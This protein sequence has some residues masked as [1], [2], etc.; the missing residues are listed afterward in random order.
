MNLFDALSI[1]DSI[2]YNAAIG[3]CPVC[4]SGVDRFRP[5]GTP[6]REKARCPNCGSLE[7]HRLVWCFFKLWTNLFDGQAKSVLHIAPERAMSERIGSIPGVDYLTADLESPLAM[8]KM[9]LTDIQYPDNS[10]DVILCSHVLEHIPD[11]G[12]AMREMYRVLKP[13]GWAAVQ[14]PISGKVTYENWGAVSEEDRVSNF[15]Q[16]DHVRKYGVDIADRLKLAGFDVTHRRPMSELG[17]LLT[18]KMA[19]KNQ[20]IFY[21]VKQ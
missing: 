16:W 5:F 15:G 3:Y 8:V 12:A 2:R 19:I 17:P 9:D 7:R 14:V 21:C 13:G 11:D 18:M 20:D 1:P 4:A 10:F 6:R